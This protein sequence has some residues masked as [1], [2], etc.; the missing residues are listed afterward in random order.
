MKRDRVLEE[1]RIADGYVG[2]GNGN[3]SE[4]KPRLRNPSRGRATARRCMGRPGSA[5]RIWG[6]YFR[7]HARSPPHGG[8]FS[9]RA[10][11]R[12]P[13]ARSTAIPRCRNRARQLPGRGLRPELGRLVAFSGFL[14]DDRSLFV[15][16]P[17]ETDG[18]LLLR[19]GPWATDLRLWGSESRHSADIE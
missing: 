7:T 15:V 19:Y 10:L 13:H 11:S 8:Q 18:A 6:R 16:E 12:T 9:R 14:P 2:G 17:S 1:T 5:E 3:S 4:W